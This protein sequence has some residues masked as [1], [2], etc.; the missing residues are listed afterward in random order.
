MCFVRSLC[1]ITIQHK[2]TE[3]KN[4]WNMKVTVIPI[5]IGA[6]ATVTGG[7]GN[8]RTSEHNLN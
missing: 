5:V 3:K 4:Y 2:R 7:L 8:K 6:L 1:L